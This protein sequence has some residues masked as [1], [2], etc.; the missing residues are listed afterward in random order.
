[1]TCVSCVSGQ[2]FVSRCPVDP[3]RRTFTPSVR[4]SH[5][6]TCF[7]HGLPTAYWAVFLAWQASWTVLAIVISLH[8]FR[9]Q[10]F[11][12]QS[13][14]CR[15]PA[16]LWFWQLGIAA[17]SDEFEAELI[18]ASHF[19]GMRY[20]EPRC[21]GQFVARASIPGSLVQDQRFLVSSEMT[22]LVWI[23]SRRPT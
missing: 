14:D 7:R 2:T 8:G 16:A 19:Q 21:F 17:V 6:V 23:F 15:T 20:C 18:L 12:L 9:C 13:A 3:F 4:F 22:N 10:P 1:M 5:G 11:T